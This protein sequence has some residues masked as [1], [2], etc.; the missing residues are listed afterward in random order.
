MVENPLNWSASY[1]LPVLVVTYGAAVQNIPHPFLKREE[2]ML[3]ISSNY[4]TLQQNELKM[5]SIQTRNDY[6]MLLSHL[7]IWKADCSIYGGLVRD[8]IVKEEEPKDIDCA[9]PISSK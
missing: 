7:L 6:I 9:L 2:E 8:W 3:F 1:V 4:N 5:D